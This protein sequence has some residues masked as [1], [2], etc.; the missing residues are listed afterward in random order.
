M[1]SM[2]QLH[3]HVLRDYRHNVIDDSVISGHRI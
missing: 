1:Q 3:A 2:E